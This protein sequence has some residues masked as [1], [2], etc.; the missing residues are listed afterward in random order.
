MEFDFE[1]LMADM[2]GVSDELREVEP[3]AV[4]DAVFAKFGLEMEEAYTFAMALL[5][6]TPQAQA[7]LSG[8]KYHAFVDK[9]DSV[10]LMKIEAK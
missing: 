9:T 4:P 2:L 1:E 5:K 6:R 8:K 3:D 10:M 7:G